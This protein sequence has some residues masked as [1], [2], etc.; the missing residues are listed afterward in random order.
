M[1]LNN[2]V[3]KLLLA[4][5]ILSFLSS[6]IFPS[7]VAADTVF[8][9]NF[10]DNTI[11]FPTWAVKNYVVE[12]SGSFANISELSIEESSEELK[13]SGTGTI[14]TAFVDGQL[15]GN[16]GKSLILNT[17]LI[18]VDTI[19]V[20]SKVRVVQGNV[21]FQAILTIEFDEDNRI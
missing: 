19:S 16:V 4:L 10:N 18:P 20:E 11:N 2:T 12:D 5:F 9:D 17:P 1:Y 6:L 14:D 8:E 13:I 3:S 15:V 7:S 21:G